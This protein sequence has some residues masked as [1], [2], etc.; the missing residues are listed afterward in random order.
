[1]LSPS[2]SARRVV[3]HCHL[4]SVKPHGRSSV[5]ETTLLPLFIE[6]L[7]H[8][9]LIQ[10]RSRRGS[11][12][13]EATLAAL[14]ARRTAVGDN[15]EAGVITKEAWREKL[16]DIARQEVGLSVMRAVVRIAFPA[17]LEHD[18]PERVNT[19]LR[20]L[21]DHVTVDMAK[22][23]RKGGPPTLAFTWRSLAM[24][25]SATEDPGTQWNDAKWTEEERLRAEEWKRR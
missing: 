2:A 6:E 15:Y 16:D 4:D 10:K 11:A 21:L 12:A 3:Y 23:A 13:D 9:R 20:T 17:D 7:S 1:M 14:D 24:R 19:Y 5:A 18:D 25:D 22:P 8:A